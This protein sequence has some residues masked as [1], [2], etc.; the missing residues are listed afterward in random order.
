MK[1]HSSAVIVMGVAGAGKS[2]VAAGLAAHFGAAFLE[3]D[4]FHP[5]A[6]V[7]KMTHGRPLTDADRAPW[8]DALAAAISATPAGLVFASC[9]AL[10]PGVRKRLSDGIGRSVEF[11]LLDAP[12]DVILRRLE[13]RRHHFMKPHMLR[14]QFETLKRPERAI[15]IDASR[16]SD[17]VVASAIKAVEARLAKAD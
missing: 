9:S 1:T 3:G 8:I 2:T 17:D 4:E 14:S 11:V 15:V 7:D 16:Q 10:T 12:E 6:N 13:Q 5:A